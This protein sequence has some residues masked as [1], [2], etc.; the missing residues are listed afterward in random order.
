MLT[1]NTTGPTFVSL[2]RAPW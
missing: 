1:E 2:L